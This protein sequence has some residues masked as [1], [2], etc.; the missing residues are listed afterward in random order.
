MNF[1]LRPFYMASKLVQIL[2]SGIGDDIRFGAEIGVHRGKTSSVLLSAFPDMTLLMVDPYMPHEEMS[3]DQDGQ[4]DVM[5]DMLRRTKF[6]GDRAQF[7]HAKSEDAHER[8]A[9]GM[10]DFVFVD[11]HHIFSQVWKDLHYWAPRV[12]EGGL[13]ICHDWHTRVGVRKAL[14]KYT[15][16]LG[17]QIM[18]PNKQYGY[19]VQPG[20][21]MIKD[22]RT[23]QLTD[24][25]LCR[26]L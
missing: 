5:A 13:V 23:I 11:A 16:R 4:D 1:G 2:R 12:R 22:L 24:G 20:S 15:K 10:F 26:T 9:P 19:F 3:L 7:I 21:K 8:F 6:F 25:E 17:V 18:V 14:R